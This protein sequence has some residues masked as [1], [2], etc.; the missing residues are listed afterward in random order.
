MEKSTA[1]KFKEN[2]KKALKKNG[3]LQKDYAK[4][5]LLTESTFSNHITGKRDLSF[6]FLTK[7]S[8]DLNLDLNYI[9]KP[10][11]V[12]L[13]A[14]TEDELALHEAL[15]ALPES[16]REAFYLNILNIIDLIN[17]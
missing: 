11:T 6:D 8:T 13:H 5:L 4:K 17:K 14:L 7:V 3:Y 2:V 16:K 9:F 10:N 1:E 12:Q 15:K